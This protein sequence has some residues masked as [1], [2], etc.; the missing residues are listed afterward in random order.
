MTKKQKK[1]LIVLLAV[2]AV[3][4][5]LFFGVVRPLVNRLVPEKPAEPL[6]LLEGESYY[7]NQG[8]HTTSRVLFPQFSRAD[9]YSVSVWNKDTNYQFVHVLS[10]AAAD[11][12]NYFLLGSDE[13]GDGE[14]ELYMPELSTVFPGFEYS[15]LYDDTSKIP[16]V[17][18][19]TG[20]CFFKDRI[21]VRANDTASPDESAYQAI[22]SNYGLADADHPSYYEVRGYAIDKNRNLVFSYTDADKKQSLVFR[23]VAANGKVTYYTVDTTDLQASEAWSE[24]LGDYDFAN[25]GTL[26]TGALEELRPIVDPERSYRV[27]VGDRTPD[28]T[29]YYLRVE[30][31]DVVY[32]TGTSSVGD[33]VNKSLAYY[34]NPRVMAESSETYG[35]Y[36][37]LHFGLWQKTGAL[38]EVKAGAGVLYAAGNVVL[39]GEAIGSE[40]G[41]LHLLKGK[42][43]DRLYAALLGKAVGERVDALVPEKLQ[44][45]PPSQDSVFE[46]VFYSIDGIVSADRVDRTAG[47]AVQADDL[48]LVT[49]RIEMDG[50][51]SELYSGAVDLSD[52]LLADA[53][54]E[55]L[56]GRTVGGDAT[57][58]TELVRAR[59]DLGQ[60]YA[61]TF[62]ETYR[63]AQIIGFATNESLSDINTTKNAALPSKGYAQ[64][65]CT[66][67]VNGVEDGRYLVINLEK[68]T[69]YAREQI[70]LALV[71]KSNGVP[72]KALTVDVVR[73]YS[74]VMGYVLYENLEVLSISDYAE[75]L[76]F[77]F[78]NELER[79]K[80]H[81]STSI[82]EITGPLDRTM[83]SLDPDTTQN[84]MMN[85]ANLVGSETLAVGITAE[86][87]REFG[88]D[89]Y[90]FYFEYPFG[91]GEDTTDGNDAVIT[92]SYSYSVPYC[93]YVSEKQADGSYYVASTL[94]GTVVR[95]SEELFGFVDYSFTKN[96][97]YSSIMQLSVFDI[98]ELSFDINFSDLRETHSF[99]L[100]TN[101]LYYVY[102][103]VNANGD[104]SWAEQKR[105]YV[106]YVAGELEYETELVNP[107]K[108]LLD[109]RE[110]FEA[111]SN[112]ETAYYTW[113]GISIWDNLEYAESML[114]ENTH[115]YTR[116]G[117]L[118]TQK[119]SHYEVKRVKNGKNLDRIYLDANGETELQGIDFDGV[120][121]LKNLLLK[122]FTTT[123]S[124]ASSADL[125][126]A[127]KTELMADPESRVFAIRLQ[128]TDGRRFEL[129]FY[130]YSDGRCLVRFADQTT[131]GVST[132][133]Y[134]N[135]LEVKGLVSAVRALANGAAVDT[136][137]AYTPDVE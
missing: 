129:G 33:V 8:Y 16:T 10:D 1:S 90:V 60:P 114:K 28:R 130:R 22:L 18:S 26:Y 120:Y 100:T 70:R 119:G 24:A 71:G 91:I 21:Y 7:Y 66:V 51:A 53:V 76:S 132:E 75:E 5:A 112:G 108:V 117:M 2:F 43:N 65:Y 54:R 49:Y 94:Y 111:L 36:M 101:P 110:Y 136:D 74:A 78:V 118:V 123:Y 47:A 14:S 55:A 83:Y 56:V 42:I 29:G 19:V 58:T 93:I 86:R 41:M 82:Y 32:T 31:R 13:D 128:M 97:M 12:D 34:V 27:Y 134:L 131:G 125:S 81:G 98:A 68:E 84:V 109:N 80:F 45:L 95:V 133:L 87:I 48:L 72:V 116:A 113:G 39:N 96:W 15:S 99:A 17:I 102:A 40:S 63:I 135:A 106:S 77:E 121:N 103:G 20:S 124:G 85:F 105:V 50:E 3:L 25:Y 38:S 79:D 115:F 107:S 11:A 104:R 89:A 4:T 35:P 61:D 73:P 126:E 6:D 88:L 57:G 46:Y 127:E 44:L 92:Y 67:V 69:T 37:A 23:S 137:A 59:I 30:G 64:I 62:T 9:L 122:I 52:P